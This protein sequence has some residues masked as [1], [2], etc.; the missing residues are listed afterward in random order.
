MFGQLPAVPYCSPIKILVSA[1]RSRNVAGNYTR[2]RILHYFVPENTRICGNF[3]DVLGT[4]GDGKRVRGW[5]WG[6]PRVAS[7][8]LFALVYDRSFCCFYI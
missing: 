5:D 6:S 2:H 3:Y 1:S 4:F 7:V 8:L